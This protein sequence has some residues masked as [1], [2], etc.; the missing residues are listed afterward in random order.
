M[1]WPGDVRRRRDRRHPPGHTS[2]TRRVTRGRIAAH[3]L[4]VGAGNHRAVERHLVGEF[5]ERLPQVLPAPVAF[6]VLAIDVR[7]HGNRRRQLQERSVAL[8]GLGNHVI[9]ASEP[10]VA[11]ER[12]EPA[13]DHRG[14][15][16]PGALEHQRHHRRRRRLAM[17]AGDGDAVAQPHQLGEHLGAR[18]DGN[19][20]AHRFGGFRIRRRDRR[21]HHDD[22]RAA[23]VLGVVA[24]G[25]AHAERA[26]A[27]R[28][29]R[30]R[31]ASDPLTS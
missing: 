15:I 18:N 21:R 14:R 9:A 19:V 6:H 26:T 3:R 23:D 8:V 10:R 16:E 28:S 1:P 17:R 24:D 11:A 25:D 30:L 20:P 13:A 22:V 5:D 4:V 27:D 31:R 2:T 29:R 7:H 12:A